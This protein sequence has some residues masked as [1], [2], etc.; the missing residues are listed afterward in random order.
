MINVIIPVYNNEDTLDAAI[1][2]VVRQ[3]IFR[4]IRVLIS[5]DASTDQ[6]AKKIADWAEK[7]SNI[8]FIKNTENLGV[9]GNYGKLLS[10]CDSAFVAPIEA[11]DV[12]ISNTRLQILKTFLDKSETSACFNHFLVKDGSQ[13]RLGAARLDPDRY[14]RIS[15]FDL[16]EENS[17]ASFTNCVY[18]TTALRDVLAE[19]RGSFGYDWLVNTIIAAR[20]S[21][22]DFFPEVLSSYHISPRGAWSSLHKKRKSEKTI[23]ALLAMKSHLPARYNQNIGR[24]AEALRLEAKDD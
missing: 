18:K 12:W 2:S 15:A 6:S 1:Q 11:D 17:P 7:H 22:V 24:R 13:Y 21:G 23:E 20:T 14:A 9:M 4:N 5:D 8:E 16:I 3:S 10:I 19:T